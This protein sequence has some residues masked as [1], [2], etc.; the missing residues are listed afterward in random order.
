VSSIV[1]ERTYQIGI[2]MAL[3]ATTTRVVREIARHGVVPTVAGLVSGV[4]LA[5]G[6]GALVRQQLFGIQP[7]DPLTLI[8][9]AVFMLIVAA[10]ASL[11]PALRAAKV[12][13]AVALR[14]ES[15]G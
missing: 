11:V 15:I 10:A 5:L 1:A 4:P 14:H 13:P 3:G 9:V 2:R 7:T 12:N 6:A 8:A